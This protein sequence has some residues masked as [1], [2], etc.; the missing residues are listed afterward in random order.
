ME[1]VWK[2]CGKSLEKNVGKM[3]EK[4]IYSIFYLHFFHV[5]VGDE[6]SKEYHFG[7]LL[8]SRVELR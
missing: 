3:S 4:S 5:G 7:P 1:K 8:S 6:R 2:K